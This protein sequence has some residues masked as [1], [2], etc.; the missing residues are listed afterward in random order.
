M[1]RNYLLI[2]MILTS[3]N[4]VAQFNPTQLVSN[5]GEKVLSLE[6]YDVSYPEYDSI[7]SNMRL[8]TP[9][10]GGWS[11]IN[12]SNYQYF[13]VTPGD[14]SS[15]GYILLNNAGSGSSASA[16][17]YIILYNGDDDYD[18][19]KYATHPGKLPQNK[20][21]RV[22]FDLKD[23]NHWVIDRMANWDYHTVSAKLYNSDF[24]IINRF[25]SRECKDGISIKSYCDNNTIQNCRIEI[26]NFHTDLRDAP[27]IGIVN[28]SYNGG[29]STPLSNVSMKNNKIL[30]NETYNFSDGFQTV[31][32]GDGIGVD[33]Q[34]TIVENNHF[35]IDETVY[36][37]C[38][39]SQSDTGDC[40][41]AENAIDLK[42]GSKNVNNRIIIRNNI[43]WGFKED[44]PTNSAFSDPG[45]AIVAHYGVANT[46]I[47]N[48]LI[49]NS[50]VGISFSDV[51]STVSPYA[52]FDT[53]IKDN[54]LNHIKRHAVGIADCN[55]LVYSD[56]LIKDVSYGSGHDR[57]ASGD[58]DT[59]LSFI[60][61]KIFNA[62]NGQ[63]YPWMS[64]V[65]TLGTILNNEYYLAFAGDDDQD[66][67]GIEHSS[68]IN[69]GSVDP[70]LNYSDFVFITD[71]YT[72]SPRSITIPKIIDGCT[73]EIY[74]TNASICGD[75]DYT[76]T[77]NNLT[78][79][80]T[81]TV[82][83]EVSNGDC[84]D[85]YI[86]NLTHTGD[87]I[88][89]NN[90]VLEAECANILGS[91]WTEHIN[92]SASNGKH[93]Q[94]QP[95]EWGN[96]GHA[97]NLGAD[98]YMTYNFNVSTTANY[99]INI[100]SMLPGSDNSIWY[101]VNNG[102]WINF[103]FGNSHI[104]SNQ[105]FWYQ[106]GLVSLLQGTNILQV[107]LR[108]GGLFID[109]IALN[110][111]TDLPTS[112]GENAS[113]CGVLSIDDNKLMNIQVYPN[114][115]IDNLNINLN[116]NT[117]NTM[118]TLYTSL[119]IKIYTVKLVNSNFVVD[120]SRFSSG[121]YFINIHNEN[122]NRQIKIIKK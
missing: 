1:K 8:I 87:C 69:H 91:Y 10:N 41:Y 105:Y 88:D 109:K 89:T 102:T 118:V 65:N 31:L 111:T 59:N 99:T 77:F 60:R 73:G 112:I 51:R 94:A 16:K 67:E 83:V 108:E 6:T 104:N 27:A 48:N 78:Y 74:T 95:G 19:E 33:C 63:Y 32:F 98:A 80:S 38:N 58:R 43:M 21:A 44:D 117:E 12:S 18:G 11:D 122:R 66:V 9:T 39:G 13:Y 57:W 4:L 100:R 50:E 3:I 40:A 62:H 49:F 20:L 115:V 42:I 79:N 30:N 92:T 36:T 7:N 35:Y 85:T 90:I 61:N 24:N 106:D 17:K 45:A 119:G 116:G 81:Q 26:N 56:N 53:D 120:L 71:N 37:N 97:E 46:V 68:D 103:D 5:G 70:T 64:N 96:A 76:W 47:E 34:G 2:L 22:R 93:M 15:L 75:N 107:S 14:Y 55:S 114:P 113:N 84:T 82:T 54:A 110:E 121:I 23:T 25:Y 86:L 28:F 52:V 72:N 29:G 101:R